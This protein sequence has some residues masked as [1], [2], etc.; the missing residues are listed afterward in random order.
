MAEEEN[1]ESSVI[2]WASYAPNRT[3]GN[4]RCNTID[5]NSEKKTSMDKQWESTTMHDA[6]SV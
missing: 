2:I 4:V 5:C 1:P 6:K 3:M